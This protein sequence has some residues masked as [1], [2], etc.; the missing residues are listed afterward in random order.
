MA[1]PCP[2][3]RPRV[4]VWFFPLDV[5]PDQHD[6]L[7]TLLS[8][9]EVARADRFH[10]AVDRARWIAARSQ[11]RQQL[12]IL[13]SR[14][15]RGLTF[16][17]DAAGR[18]SL[19]GARI[20]GLDFNLA[21]SEA[22][23][24]LAVSWQARVGVDIERQR[25]INPDEEDFALA[26]EEAASL[27]ASSGEARAAAFFRYWTLKEAFL[28]GLGTGLG[29]P[30]QSFA[31]TPSGADSP[32]LVRWDG[33]EMQTD[34]WHFETLAPHDRYCASVAVQSTQPPACFWH[35]PCTSAV[36]TNRWRPAS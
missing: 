3:L 2:E 19:A 5:A 11:L 6:H 4:D 28:K 24:V 17:S 9:G 29:T 30:L 21:H 1:V 15:A 25:A 12:A 33:H 36:N 26:A 32:R 34:D 18:P 7:L 14:D 27:C 13:T 20:A 8:P 10:K 31:M 22:W 23:A 16:Q 35:V